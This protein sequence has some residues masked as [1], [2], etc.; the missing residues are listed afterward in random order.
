LGRQRRQWI[1]VPS[2]RPEHE[3]VANLAKALAQ[4]AGQPASWRMWHQELMSPKALTF[5]KG[6]IDDLRVAEAMSATLLVPIDQFEEIFTIANA[7]ER[8]N[9]LNLLKLVTGP[10]RL[11]LLVI[12]TVCSDV[13]DD[14]LRSQQFTVPFD[15]DL[16]RPMPLDRVPI[17]IEGPASIAALVIEQGLSQ[18][19]KE[20]LR[21]SDALPLLAFLLRELYE[22][23]G[24]TH[25]FSQIDYD[26]LGDPAERLNPIE[27]AVRRRAD[28]TL[29]A[30]RP[31]PVELDAL[32]LAFIP[33]LVCVREDET[34][35]RQP[36]LLSTLPADAHRLIGAFVEA[37][38]LSKRTDGQAHDP[39][40]EVAHE[41]LFKAWPLL[42][43]WLESERE[44]LHGK[45]LL[46]R[47]LADFGNAK[48]EEKK[49]A[50]LQGIQ[51]R[52]A[53]RW[54]RTHPKGFSTAELKF[55]E[56][57]RHEVTRRRILTSAG[58][59]AAALVIAASIFLVRWAYSE[60]ALKTALKCD[61]LAAED[62]NEVSLPALDETSKIDWKLAVPA[63]EQA[64]KA[65]PDNRRLMDEL[66]RS[67]QSAG[68]FS[69]AITWYSKAVDRGDPWAENN[70]GALY[71][72]GQHGGDFVRGVELLRSAFERGNA[73]AKQNHANADF[74]VIF[75]DSPTR[76][77]ILENALLAGGF[78]QRQDVSNAWSPAL[79][80]ALAA[81]RSAEGLSN[82]SGV[83][84]Q[85]L[86]RLKVVAALATT[87]KRKE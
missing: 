51:L 45:A 11:P 67:Y 21:S 4:C 5:L 47:A 18:R 29:K 44:F 59:L 72:E 56:A 48:A 58:A 6:V 16:L 82:N 69:D 70:L 80:A 53:E 36:A 79:V 65:D 60:F 54:I 87:I 52:R 8:A 19:I 22:R 73:H 28:D 62:D 42:R 49:A 35:V 26:S 77:A 46:A 85:V 25:R 50:L 74:K 27:N 12:G 2:F 78:L 84:L 81:F 20:D 30:T 86:D 61:L 15:D 24:S 66:G 10:Q 9:I 7:D 37:R 31:A 83:T 39:I 75:D 55:I 43:G 57:S 76:I 71:L 40:I 14:L 68:R 13:L 38:L 63:C 34:L 41:S 1:L 64:V 32:K 23:F 3:P 17:V 33:Y